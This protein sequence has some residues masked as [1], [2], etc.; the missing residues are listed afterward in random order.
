M[1]LLIIGFL[2]LLFTCSF[3]VAGY[4]VMFDDEFTDTYT[5]AVCKEN[6]CRDYEFTCLNGQVI[7]SK[8]LGGFVIFESNW[9]DL[10]ID[11]GGC[12]NG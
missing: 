11:N 12:N 7:D 3:F 9:T 5:K 2:L 10:R 4:Y 8:A 1:K 6:M